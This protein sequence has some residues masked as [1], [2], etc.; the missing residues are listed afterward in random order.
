[1]NQPPLLKTNSQTGATIERVAKS[2]A[3]PYDLEEC[4]PAGENYQLLDCAPDYQCAPDTEA[5]TDNEC[6]DYDC[7]PEQAE[8]DCDPNQ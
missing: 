3:S 5:P 8:Q 2:S 7:C 1:M 6:P 4:A